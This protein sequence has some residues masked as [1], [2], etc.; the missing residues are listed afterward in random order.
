MHGAGNN[1]SRAS[2]PCDLMHS[3]D[4]R[5]Y[6]WWPLVLYTEQQMDQDQGSVVGL[7]LTPRSGRMLLETSD[8]D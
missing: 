2:S 1:T 8:A 6:E 7:T 3:I 4:A 5:H